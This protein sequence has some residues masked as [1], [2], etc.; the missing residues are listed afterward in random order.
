MFE[1]L[2]MSA[3]RKQC[4][5]SI[6]RGLPT[7]INNCGRCED[8]IRFWDELNIRVWDP[9]QTMND[10]KSIKTTYGNKLVREGRDATSSRL[11]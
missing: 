5:V 2:L 11:S 3:Y 6:K 1:K 9:A 10:L 8:Q 7:E 4:A